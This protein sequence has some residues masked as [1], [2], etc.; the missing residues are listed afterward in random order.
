MS[1]SHLKL[2]HVLPSLPSPCPVPFPAQTDTTVV[3]WEGLVPW[4]CWG[5]INPESPR[6]ELTQSMI[7]GLMEL[8]RLE[9]PSEI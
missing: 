9:K 1:P 7:Y 3:F 2:A 5:S 6:A 4:L 8:V